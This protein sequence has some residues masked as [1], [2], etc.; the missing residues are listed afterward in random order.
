[1][2]IKITEIEAN[3]EDLKASQTLGT[4][5]SNTLR[6]AFS[7]IGAYGDPD[8]SPVYDEEESEGE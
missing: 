2:K 3:T 4:A 5:F 1:M 7:N 8:E 6:N